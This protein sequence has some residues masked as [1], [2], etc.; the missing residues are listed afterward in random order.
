MEEINLSTLS[1]EEGQTLMENIVEKHRLEKL[2]EL[3]AVYNTL[4]EKEYKYLKKLPEVNQATDRP[5]GSEIGHYDHWQDYVF[6]F[7]MR[8]IHV[9][10][11]LAFGEKYDSV[12]SLWVPNGETWNIED[13]TFYNIYKK[14]EMLR[15]FLFI[16]IKLPNYQGHMSRGETEANKKMGGILDSLERLNEILSCLNLPNVKDRNDLKGVLKEASTLDLLYILMDVED[17]ACEVGN[18]SYLHYLDFV[19]LCL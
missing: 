12:F 4:P 17:K 13:S 14:P 8:C 1:N 5:Y 19:Q 6:S 7:W 11:C 15:S 2:R 16:Y 3:A 18:L 9:P 10:E